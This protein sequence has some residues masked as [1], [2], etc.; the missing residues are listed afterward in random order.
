MKG[1]L[2][3]LIILMFNV[4]GFAKSPE[5]KTF[6]AL[7]KG[8]ELK[9]LGTNLKFI[10]AQFSPFFSTKT[11]DGNSELA[12]LIEIP[13]CDF[14]ECFLGEFLINLENGEKIKLQ[15]LAFRL[16]D[17]TE[18]QSTHQ[19]LLAR[20]EDELNQKKKAAKATKIKS[21]ASSAPGH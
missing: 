16:F 13:S 2:T 9:I 4:S 14:D 17:L 8:K 19:S 1:F 5:S 15:N 6:L 11:Y 21:E 12:L 3:I 10:E 20:Y 7:F 18:G